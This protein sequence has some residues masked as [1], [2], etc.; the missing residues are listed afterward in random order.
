MSGK[1]VD[2]LAGVIKNNTGLVSLYL[3]SN[4]LQSSATV[5]LQALKGNSHLRLNQN[6]MSGKVVSNLASV[7]IF[8]RKF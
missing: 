1:V 6:N 7:I 3:N 8:K 2:D 4:N 5:V